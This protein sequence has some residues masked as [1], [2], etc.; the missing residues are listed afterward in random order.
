MGMGTIILVIMTAMAAPQGQDATI[1]PLGTMRTK[2][3]LTRASSSVT[4][5]IVRFSPRSRTG[6]LP[7]LC[8]AS[9]L[10]RMRLSVV[11]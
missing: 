11:A 10:A 5:S 2:P 9:A 3:L 8:M 1:K 6:R 7:R 4:L